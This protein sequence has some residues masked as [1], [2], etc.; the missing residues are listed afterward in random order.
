MIPSGTANTAAPQQ[1]IPALQTLPPELICQIAL[2]YTCPFDPNF[3]I[4][5]RL[6]STCRTLSTAIPLSLLAGTF[7]R[8]TAYLY[9]LDD[10]EEAKPYY[11]SA[12]TD[13]GSDCEGGC[14]HAY[15]A[16][17]KLLD[18]VKCILY[19]V[20]QRGCASVL[21][22]IANAGF[23]ELPPIREAMDEEYM[24]RAMYSGSVEIV[25]VNITCK[26]THY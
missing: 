1:R 8:Y 12:K 21:R 19:R 22:A 7:V 26:E 2:S 5:G 23:W 16:P 6:R 11:L 13:C 4:A 14:V 24:R 20:L 3:K 10:P 25:Q 9:S 15:G 18:N 17:L